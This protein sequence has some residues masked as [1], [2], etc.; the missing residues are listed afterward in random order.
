M[1]FRDPWLEHL[2]SLRGT[3]VGTLIDKDHLSRKQPCSTTLGTGR[4]LEHGSHKLRPD[5]KP[6]P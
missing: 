5:K 6:N 2:W 1:K 3:Y 4:K